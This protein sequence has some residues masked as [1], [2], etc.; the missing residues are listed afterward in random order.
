MKT[1]N[2]LSV[3]L[4]FHGLSLV[5]YTFSKSCD[6]GISTPGF[7]PDNVPVKSLEMLL[8]EQVDTNSA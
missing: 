5:Q 6:A 8:Y 7:C 1:L 4:I 3:P 2:I